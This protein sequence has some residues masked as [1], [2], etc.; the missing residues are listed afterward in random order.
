ML[1]DNHF[2]LYVLATHATWLYYTQEIVRNTNTAGNLYQDQTG[3]KHSRKTNQLVLANLKYKMDN[4]HS[5][6]YNF[7]MLHA[8]HQY[9]GEYAG[10]HSERH[11]DGVGDMGYLRR[12]QANDNT[13][14]THQLLSSW[15]LNSKWN[16]RADFSLNDIKALEPDRRENY[17]SMKEDGSYGLTGSNRQKRFFSELNSQDYNTKMILDYQ[18]NDRFEHDNYKSSLGYKGH[19]AENDLEAVEYNFSASPGAFT[20]A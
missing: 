3:A 2:S 19:F 1:G 4:K 12:Q 11:Q 5:L 9:V 10:K 20:L 16:L 18:L 8:N 15:E 6:A 13:L 14:L 7:M 17:L